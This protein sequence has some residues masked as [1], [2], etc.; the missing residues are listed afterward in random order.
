MAS[1]SIQKMSETRLIRDQL[2]WSQF[3]WWDEVTYPWCRLEG[4]GGD[5][6]AD[7]SVSST[8]EASI[9]EI[10]QVKEQLEQFARIVRN[11]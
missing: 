6:I 7:F 11:I 3:R 8:Q 5:Q 2:C 1:A 10:R 9:C 4:D